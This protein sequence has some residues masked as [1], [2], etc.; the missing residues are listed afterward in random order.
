MTLLLDY[1][2]ERLSW[3]WRESVIPTTQS[4]YNPT[5]QQLAVTLHWRTVQATSTNSG[6]L[7]AA[8]IYHIWPDGRYQSANRRHAAANLWAE[9]SHD[10][11]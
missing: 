2:L 9:S 6:A 10:A 11:R 3:P 7:A 8:S 4:S 1:R 5:P